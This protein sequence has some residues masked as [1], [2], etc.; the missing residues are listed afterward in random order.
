MKYLQKFDESLSQPDYITQS[1]FDKIEDLFLFWSDERPITWG[2]Y[3]R[4]TNDPKNIQQHA[5]IKNSKVLEN[6][7]TVH[8]FF[9]YDGPGISWNKDFSGEWN[10][11]YPSET[12]LSVNEFVEAFDFIPEEYLRSRHTIENNADIES[13]FQN[14]TATTDKLKV[15]Q[16]FNVVSGYDLKQDLIELLNKTQGLDYYGFKWNMYVVC[17]TSMLYEGKIAI[18]LDVVMTITKKAANL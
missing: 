8:I 2:S 3:I 4:M 5:P 18:E 16:N 13:L 17:S 15:L 1:D 12:R 6:C 9:R 14:R 11:S 10:K 7:T